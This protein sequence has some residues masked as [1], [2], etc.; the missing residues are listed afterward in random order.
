MGAVFRG[1][2]CHACLEPVIGDFIC[3][4]WDESQTV[5]NADGSQILRGVNP[6]LRLGKYHLVGDEESLQRLARLA[7]EKRRNSA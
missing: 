3:N 2:V 6:I 1:D 5:T 4:A 7:Q